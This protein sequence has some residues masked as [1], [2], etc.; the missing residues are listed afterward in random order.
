MKNISK[1]L[2]IAL[3]LPATQ[4]LQATIKRNADQSEPRITKINDGSQLITVEVPVNHGDLNM[5]HLA[6]FFPDNVYIKKGFRQ[7]SYTDENG[8]R[9]VVLGKDVLPLIPWI[10]GRTIKKRYLCVDSLYE[11]GGPLHKQK[12]TL[13]KT[14]TADGKIHCWK[15]HPFVLQVVEPDY[16][17]NDC[18]KINEALAAYGYD[19]FG[20]KLDQSKTNQNKE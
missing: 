10:I 6:K 5:H 1:I 17:Y 20:K 13:S 7:S 12:T 3:L 19:A 15:N 9:M 16:K 18:S 14:I 4:L 11:E 2:I 8:R